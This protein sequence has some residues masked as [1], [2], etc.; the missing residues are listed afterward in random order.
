MEF[1]ANEV[2]INRAERILKNILAYLHNE[3]YEL[4]D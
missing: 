1:F 2:R 4:H 3:Q